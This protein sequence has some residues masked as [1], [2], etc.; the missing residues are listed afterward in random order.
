MPAQI[1]HEAMNAAPN[2]PM[3]ACTCGDTGESSTATAPESSPGIVHPASERSVARIRFTA[4]IYSAAAMRASLVANRGHVQRITRT[5]DERALPSPAMTHKNMLVGT[6][7]LSVLLLSFHLA[8]DAL[9]AKPGTVAA[10][11]GNLTAILI[12][13]TLL[14]GPALLAERRSGR[15]IMLLVA[16]F[17][18]GMPVLHFMG[19]RDW[20]KH[21]AALFFVWCLIVL[22]VN[23]LFSIMLWVSELRRLRNERRMSA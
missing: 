23:G 1:H 10:G 15:I 12:L 14:S 16:V 8:Q 22:G 11:S 4:R 17:A 20:S 13:V 7:L 21:G 18:A 19:A 6:S 5:N 2:R 3:Y 9:H